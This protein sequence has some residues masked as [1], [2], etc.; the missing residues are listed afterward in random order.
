MT[1]GFEAGDKALVVGPRKHLTEVY[2]DHDIRGEV[3]IIH[4]TTNRPYSRHDCLR[5]V[6]ADGMR[7]DIP[8]HMLQPLA[9]KVIWVEATE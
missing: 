7:W 2:I 1:H 8:V 5:C 3:V 9:G 6:M 4:D